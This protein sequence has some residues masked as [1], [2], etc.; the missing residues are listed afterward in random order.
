MLQPRE[1][2]ESRNG[3]P[4]ATRTIFG[5]VLNGP[6]KRK[7]NQ[8]HT[9]NFVQADVQLNRQFGNSA[10]VSLMTQSTSSRR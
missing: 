8:A 1:V 10:T 7:R 2:R 6:L 3:G 5:W 4:F 9:A